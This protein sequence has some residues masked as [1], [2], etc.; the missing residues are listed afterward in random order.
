MMASFRERLNRFP[1]ILCRLLARKKHGLSAMSMQD[2]AKRGGLAVSTVSKISMLD[3]WDSVTLRTIDKFCKGCGID[4][5]RP[6]SHLEFFRRR[7]TVYMQKAT[8]TQRKMFARILSSLAR[9]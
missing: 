7:K 3:S 5:M 1:P 9:K 6:R 2:I 4:P 8:P